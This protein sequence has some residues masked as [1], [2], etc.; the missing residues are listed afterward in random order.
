LSNPAHMPPAE[1]QILLALADG[2]KHGHG[3]KLDVVERTEGRVHMGPGTLY[4]AIKR[5][6]RR[7]WIEEVTASVQDLEDERLRYYAAT[8][9]GLAAAREEAARMASLLGIAQ[10][11]Q[12]IG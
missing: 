4:G 12:L 10:T 5:L 7:E 1:F 11:K 9:D 6:L 2:A 3:I 8:H